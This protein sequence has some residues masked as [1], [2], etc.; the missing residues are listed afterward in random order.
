MPLHRVSITLLGQWM[1]NNFACALG[2]GGNAFIY[3]QF[4]TLSGGD[5]HCRN[6]YGTGSDSDRA[7]V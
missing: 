7:Q 2:C 4:R 1:P 3:V 6:K 5:V